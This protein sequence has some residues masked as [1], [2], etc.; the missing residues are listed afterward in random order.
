MHHELKSVAIWTALLFLPIMFLGLYFS[1]PHGGLE[2]EA[3]FPVAPRVERF[4]QAER[5]DAASVL[6][7]GCACDFDLVLVLPNVELRGAALLRRPA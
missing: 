1:A 4:S 6:F 3:L 5:S 7:A 2:N